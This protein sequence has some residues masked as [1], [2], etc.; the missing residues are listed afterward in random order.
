[1]ISARTHARLVE[2]A[3]ARFYRERSWQRLV[4]DGRAARLPAREL[5]WLA[6]WPKPDRKAADAKLLL[7]TLA[8]DPIVKPA[9]VHVPRTW[10][11]RHLLRLI[12]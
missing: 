6:A 1:V 4:D 5:D 12:G 8:R 2:L 9:P 10:A 7:R 3:R 11:L